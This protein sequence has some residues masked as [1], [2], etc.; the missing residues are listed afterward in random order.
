[1]GPALVRSEVLDDRFPA[2]LLLA[3]AGET[4]V[5]AQRPGLGELAGGAEK[6]VQL[7]LV[8]R[9]TAAVEVVAADL[10]RER[11]RLPQLQGIRGLNVKVAVAEDGGR[12]LRARDGPNLAD[13]KLL[14]VPADQLALAASAA[15]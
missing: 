14:A 1:I 10:R 12:L 9:H 7:A 8:V 2:G 11:R 5:D 6:H 13:G 4:H 3:I 15:D